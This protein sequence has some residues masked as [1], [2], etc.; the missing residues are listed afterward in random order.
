[1]IFSRITL[2]EPWETP[3]RYRFISGYV[4]WLRIEKTT[5]A[6]AVRRI[7]A[8]NNILSFLQ[9]FMLLTIFPR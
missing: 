3:G 6:V 8:K 4:F 1:S 2:E 7:A 9:A 5:V